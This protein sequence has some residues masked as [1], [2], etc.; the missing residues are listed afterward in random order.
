M[1]M[2]LPVSERNAILRAADDIISIGGRTQLSKILKGSKE[3]KLLEL[4]LDRNPVYGFYRGLTLEQILEKVDFLIRTDFLKTELLGKFPM[5]VFTPR[6]W[7]VERERRAEEFLREWDHWLD[8]GV[9]P[10]GME[11]LKE[12][13]RGMI[14]LFLLKILCS[15]DKRYIPYL[16]L[17][18]KND[19]K[20]VQSE[21]RQV[22]EDLNKRDQLRETEWSLLLR[23]R[24]QSLIVRSRHPIFLACQECG[25]PFV[26]DD[27]DLSCY[28]VD[29]LH[30]PEKCLDCRYQEGRR[31]E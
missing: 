15:G 25:G 28:K 30:F 17:W 29:G 11:Y 5:I 16:R 12:R 3:K 8:N 26:F 2:T 20:K 24:A 27:F 13:N 31:H 22:I 9:T 19:F 6:G 23:E 21:I 10:I 14:Y 7:A 18:E 4:G 1:N